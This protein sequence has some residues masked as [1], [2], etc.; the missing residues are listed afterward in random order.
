VPGEGDG[1]PEEDGEG[2]ESVKCCFAWLA[3]TGKS[4]EGITKNLLMRHI[5][6]WG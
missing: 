1:E 6:S 3:M 5:I 4:E 2:F